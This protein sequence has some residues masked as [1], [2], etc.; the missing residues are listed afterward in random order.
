MARKKR[1]AKRTT[2]KAVIGKTKFKNIIT[3]FKFFNF[4]FHDKKCLS[5]VTA[6]ISNNKGHKI[7]N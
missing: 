5:K 3:D 4:C 6:I 1:G 2:R 7:I